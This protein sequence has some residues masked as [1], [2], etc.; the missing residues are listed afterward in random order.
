MKLLLLYLP[1]IHGFIRQP[2]TCN[3]RQIDEEL[4]K[5]KLKTGLLLKQK[6]KV[7]KQMTGMDFHNDS[8][9]NVYLNQTFSKFP[10]EE[11]EIKSENFNIIKQTDFTFKDVGGMDLVKDELMQCADLLIHYKKYANYNVR[12]PKGLILEGPPGN[13]KT[14][15]AKGFSGELN[16]GFIPVSGS[17]F[18]EKYVGVGASR[19]RELFKLAKENLP[20]IIFMDEIDAIGRKRSG[21]E[22]H[23][24]DSTLNELLVNID[25]FKSSNGIF[26]MGATNRIDLL[27]DALIR[28]GRMDKKIFIG[29]PDKK[30]RMDILA[31]HLKGKPYKFHISS[32]IDMTNGYSGAQIEN[33]LNE[34]MLHALRKNKE[35]MTMT[36]IEIIANRMLVGFQPTEHIITPETLYQVAVH[37]M[38]HA[39]VGYL[40]KCKKLIKVTINLWSPTSLGFTLF[41]PNESILITKEHLMHEIMTLLG[42]RVAEDIICHSITTG[43]TH[44]FIQAKKIAEKMVVNYG[45]GKHIMIPHG[46][47]Q[48][49]EIIDQ[50]I[51]DILNIAYDATKTLLLKTEPVLKELSE[52]L[53]R[54]L[55]LTEDDIKQRLNL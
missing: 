12:V 7:L 30:T 49:C 27:D 32:L 43:A 35:Y 26:I 24:H 39:F 18:Q 23:E 4:S 2:M 47:D 53:T 51:D 21:G 33:L 22:S 25:G 55:V 46:S 10:E 13:G 3:L 52:L 16:V 45:M 40:T 48:Y 5:L 17:E 54:K 28:P 44:D 29:N 6:Q 50:E 37:E 36:D 1:F 42:G 41:E 20:C 14:L 9:I 19:V 31:I 38:G 11:R 15:M 8:D 34:A